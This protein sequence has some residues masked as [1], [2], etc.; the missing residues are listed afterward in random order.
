MIVKE[1]GYLPFQRGR[2]Q[3]IA[4]GAGAVEEFPLQLRGNSI[5]AHEY[6]RAQ[7]PQDFLFFLDELGTVV[8]NLSPV[9]RLIDMDCHP[10]F[11]V[12]KRRIGLR[13][14]AEFTHFTGRTRDIGEE[15]REFGCFRS[16]LSRS[17]HLTR[18]FCSRQ[19]H[20]RCPACRPRGLPLLVDDKL[21][22]GRSAQLARSGVEI[23]P[24]PGP[25][26]GGARPIED[27]NDWSNQT[28]KSCT[29]SDARRRIPEGTWTQMALRTA[30][31]NL[32]NIHCRDLQ[33]LD[34]P[35]IA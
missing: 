24:R 35:W 12:G 15:S 34:R 27:E 10:F 26:A 7:A 4:D 18:P 25:A 32:D 5:P 20:N 16:I 13:Q 33:K 1:A 22:W 8:V 2:L 17:E 9:N 21:I 23:I 6:G 31:S 11:V 29:A 28:H 14:I 30:G 3:Q 19:E